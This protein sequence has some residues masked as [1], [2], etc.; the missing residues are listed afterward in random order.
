MPDGANHGGRVPPSDLDAESAVLSALLLSPKDCLDDVRQLLRPAHFYADAN[1]RIYETLL[2]L[3]GEGRAVDIVTLAARLRERDQLKQVGGTPYLA[4]L[5]D[6]TPAIANVLEHG[7]IIVEKARTRQV[8][9]SCQKFASEGYG[10]VGEPQTWAQNV[11][12]VLTDVAASGEERDP[13][14][15]MAVLA[16]REFHAIRDRAARNVEL[17]GLDTKLT[18]VN[19]LTGG[20]LFAKMHCVAGRPGMGKTTYALQLIL[21]T[22]EQGL[23]AFFASAE[24]TKEELTRKLLSMVARVDHSRVKSGKM[25]HEEWRRV[26]EAAKHLAGLPLVLFY[27]PAM[28][29]AAL[30][31]ALRK[32][33]RDHAARGV[34][35]GLVAADYMQIFS[36]DG[37][38]S[39]GANRE[40]EVS[41]ISKR[42]TW[43]AGE[44]DVPVLAL[45]QLNRGVETR[46]KANKRPTLADL[47]ES[48]A[49]EQD[50]YTV[51]LL[52]RD[53]YYHRESPD[54]GMAEVDVAKNRGGP[55][56]RAMVKFTGEYG[57]FDN[58]EQ[59]LPPPGGDEY[60]AET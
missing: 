56:G 15:G 42:L 50:A 44:F 32:C 9:S 11:A 46:D 20:L 51:Q 2:E 30:R 4:Q 41:A 14:E 5:S 19:L 16:A 57:R 26:A 49:I 48:G 7:R 6:A 21:N 34:K 59:N 8:I 10:D 22:A 55:T 33:A 37:I 52:Y 40:Q 35:L 24:M 12:Q 53:E 27:Q 38:V 25:H 39:A 3:D 18:A 54:K 23:L 17:S 43:M 31:G 45:S 13:A 29:I 28:T 36:A 47:R 58:L 1:R 60:E